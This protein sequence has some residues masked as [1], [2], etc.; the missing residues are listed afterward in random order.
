M[1]R[2]SKKQARLEKV[3]GLRS[4][5]ATIKSVLADP[6]NAKYEYASALVDALPSRIESLFADEE[7]VYVEAEH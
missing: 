4:Q 7:A 5:L 3:D 2:K 1:A 6:K